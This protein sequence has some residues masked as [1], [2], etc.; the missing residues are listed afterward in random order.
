M[1]SAVCVPDELT[2][3]SDGNS[4]FLEGIL[5]HGLIHVQ[6]G[7]IELIFGPGRLHGFYCGSEMSPAIISIFSTT[8]IILHIYDR[9]INYIYT[10]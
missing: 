9:Y 10:I 2:S 4:R 7:P 3:V 8:N 5:V 1:Q 6:I